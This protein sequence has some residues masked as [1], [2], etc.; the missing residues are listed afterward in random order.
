MKKRPVTIE[1]VE[2]V[3]QGYVEEKD[4]VKKYG[5]QCLI[6]GLMANR[7]NPGKVKPPKFP[8]PTPRDPAA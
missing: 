3:C 2:S 8:P 6:L 7:I 5:I 1:T 4:P